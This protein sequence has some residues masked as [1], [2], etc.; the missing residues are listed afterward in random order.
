M[1]KRRIADSRS[2]VWR[3]FPRRNSISFKN[4]V[5]GGAK[6]CRRSLRTPTL[7][8]RAWSISTISPRLRVGTRH[9]LHIGE[10]HGPVHGSFEHKRCGHAALPQAALEG[11]CFPMAMRRVAD[12][13][14][15]TRSTAAQAHHRG[16]HSGF[17]DEHQSR[18][19]KLV[20]ICRST[21]SPA[22]RRQS[23]GA[24][25]GWTPPLRL[26]RC[27]EVAWFSHRRGGAHEQG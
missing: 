19:V 8:A 13:P 11:D 4:S 25:M 10:K 16:V 12:E 20:Y 5:L 14:L 22:S 17:V 26:H 18:R 27:A 15:A 21:K 23:G 2:A 24:V 3:F 6:A 9:L 7:D 1:R